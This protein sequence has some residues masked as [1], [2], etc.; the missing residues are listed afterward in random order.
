[1]DNETPNVSKTKT[2]EGAILRQIIELL[3][4]VEAG[5]RVRLL[6]TLATFF[7]TPLTQER[8]D[9]TEGQPKVGLGPSSFS[10]RSDL[11]PKQFLVEKAPSTDM[12]RIA[13]LGY[14][15]THYRGTPH[16]ET[17]DISALNTEAAQPKFSNASWAVNDAT[18]RGY[19]APASKGKKQLSAAGEQFV[20]TLPDREAARV[21]MQRLVS[22]RMRNTRA[23]AVANDREPTEGEDVGE[24]V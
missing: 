22:K 15:L 3:E 7:E 5:S 16:F 4:D 18:K 13:C 17:V 9:T 23:K 12:E 1:M 6:R 20:L 10:T 11:S 24:A 8:R 14:Y 2:S 19:L 21:A